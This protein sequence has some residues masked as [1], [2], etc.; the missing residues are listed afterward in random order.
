M[1]RKMNVFPKVLSG[2]IG[3]FNDE[4]RRDIAIE[5]YESEEISWSDLK[6]K[7]QIQNGS[8]NYHLKA[9][10]KT[11][12]IEN[13]LSFEEEKERSVYRPTKL[14]EK[15]LKAFR[16]IITPVNSK[17][18]F[19]RHHRQSMGEQPHFLY[20]PAISDTPHWSINT[21]AMIR[22]IYPKEEDRQKK[23]PK[24]AGDILVIAE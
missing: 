4:T 8:L 7:F 14:L 3:S 24:P 21:S 9:L 5:I 1:V 23:V 6:R 2:I 20:T 18:G 19:T 10:Q 16:E 13:V 12:L 11:G 22:N 17:E 15:T